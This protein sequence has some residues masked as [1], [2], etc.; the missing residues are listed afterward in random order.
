MR[1]PDGTNVWSLL[2]GRTVRGGRR[3]E[4]R[5]N[6]GDNPEV[7]SEVNQSA[8]QGPSFAVLSGQA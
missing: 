5:P 3:N 4:G 6:A 2:V 7:G 8:M 1:V